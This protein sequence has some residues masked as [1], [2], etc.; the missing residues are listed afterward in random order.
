METGIQS[1]NMAQNL[2]WPQFSPFMQK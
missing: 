1:P 2:G